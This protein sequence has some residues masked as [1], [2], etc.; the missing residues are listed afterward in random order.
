[1][2]RKTR[3]ARNIVK[4]EQNNKYKVGI[5][6]RLSFEN[7]YKRECGSIQNQIDYVRDYVLSQEDMILVDTYIDDNFTG[8]NFDRPGFKRMLA[9]FKKGRINTIVVK[10]LSRLGRNYVETG[11]LIERVFPENNIRFIAVNGNYDSLKDTAGIMEAVHNII[12]EYY[13]KDCSKRV[14]KVVDYRVK[15]GIPIGIVPYGYKK[16]VI[17]NTPQLVVDEE[18]A[19][20]VR[21]IFKMHLQGNSLTDIAK[22]L[23]AQGTPTPH[24]YKV[25]SQRYIDTWTT[26]KV[27]KIIKKDVY[28]GVYKT[29]KSTTALYK[30]I[31]RT[32]I[33]E[34]K[35]NVFENHHEAII[36]KEDFEKA[37][38]LRKRVDT[39]TDKSTK[40]T[41]VNIFLKKVRC[42]KCNGLYSFER[43]KS[44]VRGYCRVRKDYGKQHCDNIGISADELSEIVLPVIKEQ[45]NRLIDVDKT[46]TAIIKS[47][48]AKRKVFTFDKAIA[49]VKLKIQQT[50]DL[51]C[52]LY[53]DLTR[54]LITEDEFVVLNES[55]SEKLL[56]LEEEVSGLENQLSIIKNTLPNREDVINRIN[57]YRHKRKLSKEMVDE[58]ISQITIFED[59][60]IEVQFNFDDALK[61]LIAQKEY[62]EEILNG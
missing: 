9:D 21:L 46:V 33:D 54:N 26:E 43:K 40:K 27:I 13:A 58:F 12:N 28:T 48:K 59:K 17:D 30:N 60:K 25:G 10:D 15:Q 23:N 42:G 16:A 29:G 2:A 38:A 4:E 44:V 47:E 62:M 56:L 8:T 1:M 34:S 51:K 36:S 50:V 35:W 7:E 6:A 22:H 19:K 5:Y 45:M 14:H 24:A 31:K 20:V 57:K 53:N 37:Q 39:T 61:E 32:D 3:K 49:D 52:G 55:Y 18:A 41:F 11:N